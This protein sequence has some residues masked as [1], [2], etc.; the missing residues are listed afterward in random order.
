MAVTPFTAR[1]VPHRATT[2]LPSET[3]IGSCALTL[4]ALRGVDTVHAFEPVP[5][6]FD[7]M[8]LSTTFFPC[9]RANLH[10]Y[11]NAVSDVA[12]ETVRFSVPSR[13]AG[14]ATDI[15]HS[16]S[17]DAPSAITVRLDDVFPENATRIALLKIDV[18]GD[19]LR[20]VRGAER[21]FTRGHFDVVRFEFNPVWLGQREP[22]GGE[23][24]LEFFNRHN[25]E[26][27]TE[28]VWE[29]DGFAEKLAPTRFQSFTSHLASRLGSNAVDLIAVRGAY[30]ARLRR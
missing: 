16:G 19:E 7:L 15:G 5:S 14:H 23:H 3:S 25:F 18:E 26:I 8:R 10:L 2:D 13:N 11:R 4:A 17:V 21:L 24:L 30:L 22:D 29:R 12:N 1:Q 27:F 20:V 28:N 6:N 9:D